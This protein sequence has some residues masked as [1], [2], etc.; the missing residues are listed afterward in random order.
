MLGA[1]NF[2]GD[3]YA[4]VRQLV[5][6]PPDRRKTFIA[7]MPS[8]THYR[9]AT[10]AEAA[11]IGECNHYAKGFAIPVSP[12]DMQATKDQMTMLGYTFSE[13]DPPAHLAESYP[14]G[15]R[16]LVFPPEQRCLASYKVPHRIPLDHDPILSV[17]GGD[18]RHFTGNDTV[19]VQPDSWLDQ[20]QN[21]VGELNDEIKKG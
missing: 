3:P 19:G 1:N 17:R 14:K 20:L 2:L 11:A 21:T 10:C 7:D 4:T 8:D 15:T 9:K 13:G 12:G 5:K 16:F 18:F 6:L